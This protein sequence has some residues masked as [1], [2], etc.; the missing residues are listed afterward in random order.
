MFELLT[1]GIVTVL[2][3]GMAIVVVVRLRKHNRLLITVTDGLSQG[4]CMFDASAR[5]VFCNQRYLELYRLTPQQMVPGTTL[6]D[7]LEQCLT[8]GTFVGDSKRFAADSIA[9]IAQ[10]KTTNTAW[11]MKDGRII[12][13]VTASK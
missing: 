1:M 8:T 10:G 2:G 11:Q 13:F 12:A 3:V 7:V 6:R 9:K 5:R 4:V